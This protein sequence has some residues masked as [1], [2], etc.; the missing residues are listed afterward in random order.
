M[1]RDGGVKQQQINL[2]GKNEEQRLERRKETFF[3]YCCLTTLQLLWFLGDGGSSR[4]RVKSLRTVMKGLF[5]CF[6]SSAALFE[7]EIN[8]PIT[9]SEENSVILL[10]NLCRGALT[11]ERSP[12]PDPPAHH[13]GIMGRRDLIGL[14][15]LTR[16][17]LNMAE[18][19]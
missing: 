5:Y 13:V 15:S 12:S 2:G 17:R 8:Y 1:K 14:I 19:I 18:K 9:E 7:S 3:H 11:A 4:E 10:I 16:S 6:T